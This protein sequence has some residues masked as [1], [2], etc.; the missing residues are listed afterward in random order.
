MTNSSAWGSFLHLLT[1]RPTLYVIMPLLLL[2]GVV[3]LIK[4]QLLTS[5]TKLRASSVRTIAILLTIL[6]VLYFAFVI[7]LSV[8]FGHGPE[9]R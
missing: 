4:P 9:V 2:I 1:A 6:G 5:R 3:L 7:C 8:S